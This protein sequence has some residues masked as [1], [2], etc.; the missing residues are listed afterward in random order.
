MMSSSNLDAVAGQQRPEPRQSGGRSSLH[1]H[2]SA[3]VPVTSG[4]TVESGRLAPRRSRVWIGA[5]VIPLVQVAGLLASGDA[6]AYHGQPMSRM[7]AFLYRSPMYVLSPW[8]SA[9][10]IASLIDNRGRFLHRSRIHRWTWRYAIFAFIASLSWPIVL[11]GE[12]TTS[13]IVSTVFAVASIGGSLCDVI[14]WCI[15]AYIT[16]LKLHLLAEAVPHLASLG[17]R[18]FKVF[19]VFSCL[20]FALYVLHAYFL[21]SLASFVAFVSSG[22]VLLFWYVSF[23]A[24]AVRALHL[25]ADAATRNARETDAA[26]ADMEAVQQAAKWT[27][28]TATVTAF[29]AGTTFANGCG[30]GART[31]LVSVG[32]VGAGLVLRCSIAILDLAV[33]TLAAGMLAGIW[34]PTV[35]PE[36]AEEGLSL[37]AEQ[38]AKRREQLVRENLLAAVS[39]RAGTAA[40][41]AALVGTKDPAFLVALA[42]QRFRCISW[43]FLSAHPELILDAGTLVSYQLALC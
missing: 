32:L 26:D 18:C 33:N 11:I 28:R 43:N 19:V 20:A 13:S 9:A 2:M 7:Q 1:S 27:R 21:Q 41:I 5:A 35:A 29:A 42:V 36:Q 22:I 25:T 31:V 4:D 14:S 15:V 34:G 12:C 3:M 23:V 40:T 16:Q 24:C 30:I 38:A 6:C 10:F 8:C 39:S 17:Q 37:A